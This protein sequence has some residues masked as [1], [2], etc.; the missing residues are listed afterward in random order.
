MQDIILHCNSFKAPKPKLTIK[1]AQ[2]MGQ[3]D[4]TITHGAFQDGI[5]PRKFL[6][7]PTIYLSLVK[8]GAKFGL[9]VCCII[10]NHLK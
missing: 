5:D 3:L 10:E 1:V 2:S 7:I 4:C 8:P 6:G 9:N